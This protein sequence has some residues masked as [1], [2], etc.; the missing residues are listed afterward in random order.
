MGIGDLCIKNRNGRHKTYKRRK[1]F[2]IT[3]DKTQLVSNHNVC[4]IYWLEFA[5]FY[6]LGEIGEEKV[7]N[8]KL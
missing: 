8:R 3:I 2:G 5:W 1:A 4:G 7:E 6:T